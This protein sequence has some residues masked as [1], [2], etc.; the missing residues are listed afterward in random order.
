[1][2][3]TSLAAVLAMVCGCAAS[4]CAAFAT[5][6]PTPA[7]DISPRAAA[8]IKAPPGERYFIIVFGSQSTPKLP[9]YT[10]SWATVVKV[11]GC[12]G[13]GPVTLE[14][15]TISWMPATLAI[16]TWSPHVEPGVNL[17]MHVTIEEMLRNKER[18]SIWGPYEVGP[19]LVYRFGVQ[20]AFM[21][22]GRIGYQCIDSIGEAGRT[23]DGC[24]CIHSITDMDPLF[25]RRQYPLSYF[26]ESASLNLV[27]QLQ[28]R[29]II[30]CPEADHS[31]LLPLLC[32]DQYPLTH[33]TYCGPNLP[34]TPE[35]LERYLSEHEGNCGP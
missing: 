4:G 2:G 28:T 14:E 26:G 25:D 32:L 19:G 29:P 18:V 33:R 24:N 22:A 30:I 7:D 31:W 23:G 13:P 5:K 11:T 16:R 15:Q 12:G 17:D 34:Y 10:H 1:M 8:A 27:R 9:K 20:K 3:R 35:N 21:E 6:P